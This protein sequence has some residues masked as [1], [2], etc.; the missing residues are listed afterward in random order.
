MSE[1]ASGNSNVTLVIDLANGESRESKVISLAEAGLKERSDLQQWI[2]EHPRVV[3]NNLLLIT[4]EFDRW[5]T[6]T[7]RV[8]DRLDVLFLDEDGSPLVAE[9]KR[10]RA[11]DSV[12]LQALKYAAYCSKLTTQDL[13]EEYARY[14]EVDIDDGYARLVDHAPSL[15]DSEPGPVRIRLVAGEFG[16]AVTS[17][18]LWL[19][20]HDIDI[21]CIEV[22]AHEIEDGKVVVSTQQLIPLPDAEDYLVRRRRREQQEVQRRERVQATWEDYD[23]NFPP[24]RVAVAR[25]LF[26]RLQSY[27]DAH[28]LDWTPNF[29]S[30]WFGLQRTGGYY[31]PVLELYPRRPVR[32]SVKIPDDPERLGLVNPYPNLV[33]SWIAKDRQWAWDIP[34]LE[35]VPDVAPALEISRPFQPE[36]GPM[37]PSTD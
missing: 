33:T 22:V 14:H 37:P 26:K 25:E 6:R 21:G 24:D 23:A 5:E 28:E 27:A 12:E 16:P 36:T 17:V 4:S 11:S 20:E 3:G 15:E 10:D 1:R 31:V 2:I 34:D 30:S 7:H 32:F 35:S 9:L 18:V 13:S 19:R 8:W 29:R